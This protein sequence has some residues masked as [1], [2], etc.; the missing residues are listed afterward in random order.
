MSTTERLV[1]MAKD[2]SEI[3]GCTMAEGMMIAINQ[4][5]AKAIEKELQA[6]RETII[7]AH[8]ELI[9]TYKI[10]LNN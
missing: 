10:T 4:Y 1:G 7:A 5:Q 9:Q 6:I 2:Y 3:L 8:N